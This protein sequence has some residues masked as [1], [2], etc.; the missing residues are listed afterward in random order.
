[1]TPLRAALIVLAAAGASTVI[2][3]V[4]FGREARRTM[5]WRLMIALLLWSLACFGALTFVLH[6]S[7]L[8]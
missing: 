4:T 2:A 3:Y 8:R 7:L 6:P 5:P 1:M